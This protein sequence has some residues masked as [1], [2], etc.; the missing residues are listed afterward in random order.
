MIGARIENNAVVVIARIGA[1][2]DGVDVLEMEE[3]MD[4]YT[5]VDGIIRVDRA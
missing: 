2:D 5:I 4:V 3:A 1:C